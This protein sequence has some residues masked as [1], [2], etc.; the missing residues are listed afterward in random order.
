[1]RFDEGEI[2]PAVLGINEGYRD[3]NLE[4]MLAH[5]DGISGGN[6]ENS[7]IPVAQ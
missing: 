6:F 1:M 3:E 5:K 2:S 4:K 7:F